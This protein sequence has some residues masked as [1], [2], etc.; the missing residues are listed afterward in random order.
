MPVS[1]KANISKGALSPLDWIPP[2]EDF[3]CEYVLRFS[4]VI[5]RYGLELPAGEASSLEALTASTCD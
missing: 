4:R 2:N 1:I 3:A 5:D